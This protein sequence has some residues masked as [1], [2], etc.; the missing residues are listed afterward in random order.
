VSVK[1]H[2]S[3]KKEAMEAGVARYNTTTA[4]FEFITKGEINANN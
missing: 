3:L 2:E 1:T 4:K